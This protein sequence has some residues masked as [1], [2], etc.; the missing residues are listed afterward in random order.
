[1][2]KALSLLLIITLLFSIGIISTSAENCTQAGYPEAVYAKIDPQ[3]IGY[4]NCD[5]TTQTVFIELDLES[6]LPKEMPSW[7]D[8]FKA[9]KE[10]DLFYWDNQKQFLQIAE[11]LKNT[12]HLTNIRGVCGEAMIATVQN[13]PDAIYKLAVNEHI[14]HIRCFDLYSKSYDENN[15]RNRYRDRLLRQY[16]VWDIWLGNDLT[17]YQEV[18]YHPCADDD[19]PY[20]TDWAIVEASISGIVACAEYEK[21]VGGRLLYAPNTYQSPFA[22]DIGIYDAEKDQFFDIEDIDF[23]D[24]PD[25]YEDWQKMDIGELTIKEQPGDADGDLDVTILDATKIQR[26]IA[27][28]DSKN[29]I[30]ATGADADGDGEMTVLDATRIQRYKADLCTLDGTPT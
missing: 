2:K 5:V 10:Y 6:K 17:M 8:Y 3:V 25:L 13:H 22:F 9:H 19:K 21:I 7:P 4:T 18:Y 1:M 12:A 24:Y 23:D 30:V 15:T 14:K 16:P 28:L 20:T 11:E 27:G 26:G 29:A